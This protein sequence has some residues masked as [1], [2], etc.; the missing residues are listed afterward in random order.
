MCRKMVRF[1]ISFY[2]EELALDEDLEAAEDQDV[3]D[4]ESGLY[5]SDVMEELVEA[6]DIDLFAM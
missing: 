2:E 1:F 5:L 3:Y 4:E 6:E